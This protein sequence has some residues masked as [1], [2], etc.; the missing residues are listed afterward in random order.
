MTLLADPLMNLSGQVDES[1]HTLLSIGQ[2]ITSFFGTTFEFFSVLEST[3]LKA[4]F[5]I[6]FR[7]NFL[8]A[9]L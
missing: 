2:V 4:S 5:N 1:N 6:I 3:M 8:I 9:H 7:T